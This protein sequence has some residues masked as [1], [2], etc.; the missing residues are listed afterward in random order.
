MQY[1]LL[2][3]LH[4]QVNTGVTGNQRVNSLASEYISHVENAQVYFGSLVPRPCAFVAGPG[5]EA[6]SLVCI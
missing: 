3:R 2:T 1:L 5:N 4:L 6:N